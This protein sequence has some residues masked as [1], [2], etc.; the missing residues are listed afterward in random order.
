MPFFAVSQKT[1]LS[2]V[3]SMA[4]MELKAK[5][6]RLQGKTDPMEVYKSE[7]SPAGD[8]KTRAVDA[9]YKTLEE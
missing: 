5:G 9:V 1:I 2:N 4:M 8:S 3:I 7:Q 6:I